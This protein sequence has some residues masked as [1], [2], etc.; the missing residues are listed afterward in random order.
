MDKKEYITAMLQNL[1]QVKDN[2]LSGSAEYVCPICLKPCAAED[3]TDEHVPQHSLGG[4]KMT[5]TCRECN[6]KCG[7]EVDVYLTNAIEQMERPRFLPG[8]D[9][10][11]C[12]L[13]AEK[14]LS[15]SIRITPD[16]LEFVVDT[17]NS[18]PKV[19]EYYKNNVFK[20]DAIFSAKDYLKKQNP[21]RCFAALLKNA[22]LM[23][24]ARSGY[25][26]LLD[27]HYDRLRS[28]IRNPEDLAIPKSM[29]FVTDNR[30][31]PDGIFLIHDNVCR[32]FL[33]SHS[34]KMIATHY[35]ICFIPTPKV[36]Y[37]YAAYAL[38]HKNGVM[39][40]RLPEEMDFVNDINAVERLR[41]WCY[42]WRPFF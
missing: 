41:S 4:H 33:I 13:G 12:V 8:S 17:R 36:D 29:C 2:L 32:G 37:D 34:L 5:L 21:N 35:A 40:E 16:G 19:W 28:Q 26:I 10:K 24:F 1:R 42:S 31:I 30:H 15:S 25:A 7:S 6:S 38:L 3:L 9:R 18:H 23:L 20:I 39:L 22:Y 14:E 27:S 11:V